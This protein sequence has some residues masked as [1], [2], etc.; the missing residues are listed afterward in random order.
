MKKIKKGTKIALTVCLSF[1]IL[2]I[3]LSSGLYFGL[4][5]TPHYNFDLDEFLSNAKLVWAD[6]F[7][8]PT[9]DSNKWQTCNEEPKQ[10]RRGGYWS[11]DAVRQESGNL[12]ISTEL[13]S[14]GHFYSGAIET[15][16]KY[17]SK[18][19]YYEVRCILPPACGIW[20]AF[21]LM[22]VDGVLF[23]NGG[24][25]DIAGVEIDIMESPLYPQN[26]VS[27]AIHVSGYGKGS[28]TF[29]NLK[30]SFQSYEN[31]YTDFHTY[32]AYWNEDIYIFYIDGKEVWQTNCKGQVSHV[33]EYI[34]LSVEVGGTTVNGIP[35][36]GHAWD[37]PIYPKPTD[38]R[39][40]WSTPKEFI[41]DYVRHYQ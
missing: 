2:I 10:P 3:L 36:P 38:D 1:L 34:L 33:E 30:S 22:P 35:E 39:N 15:R 26:K 9:I 8:G 5:Y 18:Y 17:H 25:P 14:D 13:R 40:N 41:V 4:Y 6:E 16:D 23:G 27:Q 28:K 24:S 21:W 7:D 31:L 20:S 32:G 11:D 12:I 19:G 29:L 37:S